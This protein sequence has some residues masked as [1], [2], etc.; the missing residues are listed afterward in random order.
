MRQSLAKKLTHKVEEIKQK[1]RMAGHYK[2]RVLSRKTYD[3]CAD[4][5]AQNFMF[6]FGNQ[7]GKS[8]LA[9]T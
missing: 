5:V 2:K 6:I 4:D 7:P 9:E 1:Q 8:I 3:Y